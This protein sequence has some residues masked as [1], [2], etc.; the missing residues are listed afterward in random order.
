MFKLK[1]LLNQSLQNILKKYNERINPNIVKYFY[2]NDPS[3][4]KQH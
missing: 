3:G 1:S 2:N 4:Q